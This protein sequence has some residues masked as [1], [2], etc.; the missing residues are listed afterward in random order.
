MNSSAKKL[1]KIRFMQNELPA[2]VNIPFSA[3][4]S[5]KTVKN[6]TGDFLRVFRLEGIAHESADDESINLWHEQLNI[7]LRN[8]ASTNLALWTHIV[9]RRENT[10]PGGEFPEGFAKD[11]NERYS[12]EIIRGGKKMLVNEL[13]ITV[14]YRPHPDKL[15]KTFAVFEKNKKALLEN[16]QHALERLD[17]IEDTILQSL[18][19]YQPE[20]LSTYDY[21]GV[22]YSEVLEFF[23]FLVN[24]E[25]Q[26]M[27]VPTGNIRKFISTS[28]PFFGSESIALH[29]PVEVIHGA[30]LGIKE[31]PPFTGPGMLDD[32][33]ALPCELILTQSFIFKDKQS[34]KYSFERQADVMIQA[35]DLAESQ[36]ADLQSALD[37]LISNRFVIGEFHLSLFVLARS[38]KELMENVGLA[39]TALSETGMVV[40]REDLVNEAAFW[41][42]LP[43]NF[44]FRP[45]PAQVTSRN[46]AGLS[47]FHNYPQGRRVRNHW[48]D[49]VSLLRTSANSPYYFNF[50]KLDLGNTFICGPSGSGKTVIQLFMM[51]MLMKYKPR[52]VFYDKDYG[53]KIFVLAMGGQYHSLEIGK[54]TGWN[55]FQLE[56]NAKNVEFLETL[57]R[58]LVKRDGVELSVRDQTAISAAVKGVLALDKR[59]RRLF[60]ALSFFDPTDPEGIY[61]RLEQWCQG[62]RLGWMFDNAEDNLDMTKTRVSG[63]DMTQL[64]DSDEVKGPALFYLNHRQEE[65]LNGEPFVAFYDEFWRLVIEQILCEKVRD[66]LKVVRKQ[67]GFLVMGTQSLRDALDSA[68]SATLIEQTATKIFLPNPDG[69]ASDYI[70]GFNLSEKE[71]EI[72][73]TLPVGSRRF[74]VK[75][76][77]NSIVAELNLRGFDDEL[78]V[79]SGNTGNSALVDSIIN[80][81]GSDPSVWLPV[82]HER[83]KSL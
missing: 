72:I 44:E 59:D 7:L 4:V 28:R 79:L 40:A 35:G 81:V 48:G 33:L 82:F 50:H 31:Y 58:L 41:S 42:Q 8:L 83:R 75:Q 13:Y 16:Q 57:I 49:A 76:G 65:L 45:R 68:I 24:G 51:C 27:P 12:R 10:Y 32:I 71:F 70:D 63:F 53:A 73:K 56:P 78:A 34:A 20:V 62:H 23:G 38:S 80:E 52:V 64:L 9:R 46:F 67:N 47:A 21:K 2:S 37:D 36:I 74:L 19:R 39:R 61:Y 77:H 3:H 15:S 25:W 26:R 69:K 17:E 60:H 11:L 22:L 54:K 55:P 18:D 29:T 1:A 30:M 14:V 66:K 6:H 43:G 5:K